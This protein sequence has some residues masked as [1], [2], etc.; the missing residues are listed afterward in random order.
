M[1]FCEAV[2]STILLICDK[3]AFLEVLKDFPAMQKQLERSAT[4]RKDKIKSIMEKMKNE[5]SPVEV[6]RRPKLLRSN[7]YLAD[8]IIGEIN[9]RDKR[10]KKSFKKQPTIAQ[11]NPKPLIGIIP[12]SNNNS[13]LNSSMDVKS[14][15]GGQKNGNLMDMIKNLKKQ[16]EIVNS[17]NVSFT[18]SVAASKDNSP[19]DSQSQSVKNSDKENSF[20]SYKSRN[21]DSEAQSNR[22]QGQGDSE[23]DNPKVTH[24]NINKLSD[25]PIKIENDYPAKEPAKPK[26][27]EAKDKPKQELSQSDKKPSGIVSQLSGT[28]N[29]YI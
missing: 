13:G 11:V 2:D 25:D 20:T 6:D 26:K 27:E 10:K 24:V 18:N 4:T 28:Q 12:A 3:N 16:R 22:P 15:A 29:N 9:S 23:Q 1:C 7:E 14:E 19:K 17:A 5:Q 21:P 8:I